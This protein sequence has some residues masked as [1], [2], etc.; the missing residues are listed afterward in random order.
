MIKSIF[1]LK[2]VKFKNNSLYIRTTMSAKNLR[3]VGLPAKKDPPL[4]F[5]SCYKNPTFRVS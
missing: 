3:K 5:S 4:K 1:I 2:L